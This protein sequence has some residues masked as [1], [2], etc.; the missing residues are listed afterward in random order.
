MITQGGAYGWNRYS[1]LFGDVGNLNNLRL[2]ACFFAKSLSEKI[3]QAWAHRSARFMILV[4]IAI[5]GI[6]AFILYGSS[7]YLLYQ[8]ATFTPYTSDY[9]T[10]YD[11]SEDISMAW[12]VFGLS[13]AV[14]VVAD[15]IKVILVLTFAD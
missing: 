3:S 11:G 13:M 12:I 8:G 9:G 1:K 5:Q 7:L 14:S 15:I 4:I 2:S 6:S 10:L